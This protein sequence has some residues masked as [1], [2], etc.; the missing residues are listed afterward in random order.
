MTPVSIQVSEKYQNLLQDY[1]TQHTEDFI[2]SQI[3]LF[4]IVILLLI[5]SVTTRKS[6]SSRL[7]SPGNMSHSLTGGGGK[8]MVSVNQTHQK[9][10]AALGI[11]SSGKLSALSH[12]HQLHQHEAANHHHHHNFK[13]SSNVTNARENANNLFVVSLIITCLYFSSIFLHTYGQNNGSPI[14]GAAAASTN[15]DLIFSV[16]LVSIAFVTLMGIFMPILRQVH[17]YEDEMADPI[18]GTI[19]RP[20]ITQS[21][22]HANSG[23]LFSDGDNNNIIPNSSSSANTHSAFAMFPEFA[24][25]GHRRPSSMSDG[26]SSSGAG[27]RRPFAE[28]KESRRNM[29]GALANLGLATGGSTTGEFDPAL[30]NLKLNLANATMAIDTDL[31]PIADELFKGD[32]GHR[33]QQ[34]QAGRRSPTGGIMS[35]GGGGGEKRL[36]MLDVD[37]CCPR[38][39]H[40]VNGTTS[41]QSN[42]CQNQAVASGS[43]SSSNNNK[44]NSYVSTSS[45]SMARQSNAHSH[46]HHHH[47]QGHGNNGNLYGNNH[48]QQLNHHHHHQQ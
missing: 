21:K 11:G 40:V 46:L 2:Q 47:H 44:R 13:F 27:S 41:R 19:S 3:Y 26:T 37:P 15:H 23:G 8:Q 38:H 14:V 29:A 31:S 45:A 10:A 5:F 33:Q 6:R 39:G 32:H 12:S 20:V 34:H 48:H 7:N 42:K 36:I 43:S 30:L 1:C 17:R 35:G 9:L 18:S 4:M 22:L 25:T 16:T 28:T 24:Q